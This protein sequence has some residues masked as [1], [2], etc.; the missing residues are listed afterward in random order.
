MAKRTSNLFL[1]LI[2]Q[3]MPCCCAQSTCGQE[4]FTTRL[5]RDNILARHGFEPSKPGESFVWYGFA[6][7]QQV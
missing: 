3:K 5:F 2:N 4:D 6:A 1:S 7:M